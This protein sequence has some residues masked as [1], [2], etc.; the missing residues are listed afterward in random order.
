MNGYNRNGGGNYNTG[1]KPQANSLPPIV[2]DYKKDPNLFDTTA[3][4]VAEKISGTKATQMRAFYDYIIELEQKSNSE[5]FSEV[6]PFVKMLNSKA[7]YSKSRKCSSDEFV[8]MINK[9]VA[10]VKTKDDLRVFKLFFEA[11]IGFAKK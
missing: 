8:E 4:T 7:A 2:L 6:L 5:D 9:C 1:N 11:V 3:K 10:Q